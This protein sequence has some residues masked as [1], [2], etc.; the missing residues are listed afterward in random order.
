MFKYIRKEYVGPFLPNL[1]CS[2][3]GKNQGLF[4]LWRIMP[5]VMNMQD[6]EDIIP[7]L[8]GDL[9]RRSGQGVFIV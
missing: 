1:T 6:E 4:V 5:R 2:W 7:F 3:S 8:R 9:R